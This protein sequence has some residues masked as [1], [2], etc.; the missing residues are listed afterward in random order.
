MEMRTGLL[1]GVAEEEGFTVDSRRVQAEVCGRVQTE[2]GHEGGGRGSKQEK[3]GEGMTRADR[4]GGGERRWQE[5]GPGAK[6]E[7]KR[8]CGWFL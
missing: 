5:R 3:M 1:L 8:A 7:D 6:R 4:H 2:P